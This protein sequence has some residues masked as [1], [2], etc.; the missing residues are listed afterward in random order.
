MS[1]IAA[2]RRLIGPFKEFG[3]GAGALYAL[4]RVLRSLSPNLAVYVYELMVQPI[5]AKPMLPANLIKNLRFAEIRRGDPAVAEMPARPEIKESRFAQGAICLGAYR[6]DALLGYIW[7]CKGRYQEDEVRCDYELAA[8]EQSVFDFDLYVLPQHRMGIG[9]M[10]V[11]HGAN[12]YLHERGIDYTFSRLTRFNVASRRSHA[13]FGWRRVG[14]AVFV[15]LWR[16]EAMLSTIF[17]YLGFTA[18]SGRRLRLRLKPTVLQ[19]RPTT[20]PSVPEATTPATRT[21]PERLEN[22][23]MRNTR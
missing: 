19:A 4:D 15:K 5:T 20:M 16:V 9:F 17:P 14:Q 10:A 6:K 21:P 3:L 23:R 22:P 13:H 7:L 1:T 12:A 11:W 18:S 2:W 8:A